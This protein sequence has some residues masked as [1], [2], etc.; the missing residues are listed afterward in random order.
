MKHLKRRRVVVGAGVA[1]ALVLVALLWGAT[2]PWTANH[3]GYALPGNDGLPAYLFA[4][5]RRYSTTQVCAGADWCQQTRAQQS[6]P[7]CFTVADLQGRPHLWPL[8]RV[9]DMFTL[10]GA[11][12]PILTLA[13]GG[14]VTVPYIIA[15]GADCY[16]VYSLEGSP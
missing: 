7:R 6:L 14:G 9:A 10:F 11:S 12:H 1:L 5:G 8:V 3:F 13:A 15:E 16:D 4:N 2:R